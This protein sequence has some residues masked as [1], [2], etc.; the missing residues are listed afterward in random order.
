MNTRSSQG[1]V[2]R[3][4]DPRRPFVITP[5]GR[6][7]Y[8]VGRALAH[9]EE[10]AHGAAHAAQPREKP[11]R[12]Q[13]PADHCIMVATHSERG[14]LTPG[15]QQAVA[16]AALLA[17]PHCAVLLVVFGPLSES[18]ANIGADQV[19]VLAGDAFEP[20]RALDAL[21]S[22]R[23]R[24]QPV[25]VVM[26]DD[27]PDGDLGRRLAA[28]YGLSVAAHTVELTA[29]TATVRQRHGSV[30]ARRPL[31][32]LLLLDPECVDMHLP[33]RGRGDILD[34]TPDGATAPRYRDHGITAVP[35]S[36]LALEEADFIVSAGNGVH[37]LDSFHALAD[38]LGAAVGASRV[39]VDDGRFARAQQVGATGKTVASSVYIA[40]GISGAVQHLQGIKDCRHVIAINT[41]ASAPMIKRADLSIIDDTQAIVRALLDEVRA[42]RGAGAGGAGS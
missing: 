31:P 19:I 10:P 5:L 34:W 22:L 13:S 11:L 29:R 24:H 32:D 42:A 7:R 9:G 38:A 3:R 28:R 4:V 33:F 15:A 14:V 39:A 23:Q 12:L 2:R 1:P 30:Y 18:T 35:A 17:D 40:M 27:V 26:A 37:D 25:R 41:D 8:A 20:D 36:H 16:A 6:K 21:E